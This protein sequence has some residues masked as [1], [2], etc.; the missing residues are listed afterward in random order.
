M[1]KKDRKGVTE[2]WLG[3]HLRC[4]LIPWLFFYT[5]ALLSPLCVV[6]RILNVLQDLYTS[7]YCQRAAAV[8]SWQARESQEP[9]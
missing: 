2:G 6:P 8:A 3:W 5:P 4:P 9:G 1:E 7:L